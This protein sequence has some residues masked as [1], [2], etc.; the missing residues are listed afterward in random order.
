MAVIDRTLTAAMRLQRYLIGRHWSGGMLVGPDP[1]IRFNY[2][3]G[4]FLK[5]YL[6]FLPWRDRLYYIQGQG[7]WVLGNWRLSQET[8]DVDY[9]DVAEAASR[10]MI[11]HQRPDGAW[12][13]PNPEWRGRVATAEGTWG[14]ISL[15][16]SYRRTGAGEYLDSALRWHRFVEEGIGY[17]R[18]GDEAAV[19]YFAG[20]SGTRIPNNTAFYLRFLAELADATG[21]QRHLEPTAPLV[22]FLRRAQQPSGEFPYAVEG[23]DGAGGRPHF[24][25]YQYNAFQALD[26]MRYQ[27]L[28][29]DTSVSPVIQRVL[30]FLSSGQT[31]MGYS[32]YQCNQAHG[33]VVYHTGAMAAAFHMAEALGF[34]GYRE[35]A[36]RAYG[37]LLE[38]QRADGGFPHSGGD[39]RLL[40]D[41]RSYPRYQAMILHH[42][43]LRVQTREGNGIDREAARERAG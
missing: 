2:R 5:S 8:G 22:S 34:E 18:K 42:L 30:G 24:Q 32:R 16:E 38:Q 11:R 17:Q 35:R 23:V 27:E 10:G 36:D 4:R 6:S 3:I 15:V 26:L 40:S 7:Y 19:N 37:H 31:G 28:S 29:G 12:E 9:R 43:L 33:R 41:R 25:C 20:R 14:A 1:G 21:D 13:Y 39:Y